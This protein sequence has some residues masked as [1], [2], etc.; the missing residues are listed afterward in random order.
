MKRFL[1]ALVFLAGCGDAAT[2]VEGPSTGGG[3]YDLSTVNPPVGNADLSVAA[4]VD[5]STPPIDPPPPD[6][7][8]KVG[9][10]TTVTLFN[11]LVFDNGHRE[12]RASVTMPA[13]GLYKKITLHITLACPGGGCDPWDR[14][15]S[16]GLVDG[17]ADLGPE[18]IIELGRFATPYGRGGSWDIDVTDL[19]PL[20][21]GAR[22]VK[23]FI[24]TW[25]GP[26]QGWG[27]TATL[28]YVG[29]VPTDIPIAAVPLSWGN[30]NVG[31]SQP[32]NSLL[33]PQLVTMPSSVTHAAVRVTVTGHGQGNA[34]NCAEFCSLNHG[35]V[36]DGTVAQQQKVWRAD[37]AQNPVQPQGGSWQ[38]NRA[39][40]CPGADVRPWRVDLG[41]RGSSFTVGY[42]LDTYVNTCS[43]N[44]C[45]ANTC[46]LGTGCAYDN[47][48]HTQPYYALS[49]IVIGYQ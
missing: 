28:I 49:A 2:K 38:Y 32:I 26:P 41:P 1:P 48:N 15:A 23:G 20:L 37:C 33:P 3:S 45:T 31:D 43:P 9:A 39:G 11:N 27:L 34:G 44:S 5:L 13:D 40:W 17:G 18:R 14:L 36:V 46:S 24:D 22:T 6:L 8:A 16:I 10:D 21:A 4:V 7:G 29:G 12:A 19:R 30:F 42:K 35:I 47:G 25:I